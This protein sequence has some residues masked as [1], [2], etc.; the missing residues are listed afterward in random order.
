[1]NLCRLF[2]G[3]VFISACIVSCHPQKGHDTR[4]SDA[5]SLLFKIGEKKDFEQMRLMTDSFEAAGIITPLNA[6]RW[7]G[8]SYYHE[9]NYRISENYYRKALECE[10]NTVEDQLS[11]NKCARRLSELLLVKGDYEGALRVAIPA[12]K[13]MDESGIGSDIDYAIL[14]NNIGCGQLNLGQDKEANESFLSA[15]SYYAQRLLVDSTGRGLQEVVIGYIYTIQAYINTHN[16]AESINW[17]DSADVLLNKFHQT[18]SRKGYFDEYH[19]RIEIMRAVAMQGQ[20]KPAEAAKAYQSFLKTEYSKT[21]PARINANDYLM[22]AHRYSEAA[23]N[24]SYLD[25]AMVH[26]GI[27][28]SLDNV[29]LYML[30]KFRANK[31]AGR[32]DSAKVIAEK[33]LNVLDSAITGQKNDATDELAIIYDTQGKEQKIYQQQTELFRERMWG[34]V[35]SLLLIITFLIIYVL[36]RRR[37]SKILAEKNELLHNANAHIEEL[38]RLK[39][40][41]IQKIIYQ[42]KDTNSSE[43]K[44]DVFISYSRANLEIVKTI[45]K[46]I[47]DATSKHC[48]MDLEGIESGAPRFTESIIEGIEQCEVFLFMRTMQSQNSKY[49]LLEL[50]YAT[51]ESKKHV[52]IVNIDNSDMTKE[53]RFLYGLTN[54]ID[55]GNEPQREKLIRDIVKWT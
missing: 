21:S 28:P 12:M 4:V 7:R 11:Y 20:N 47:E 16:Y 9:G 25:Q 51:E 38:S 2:V 50:N 27:K 15:H 39:T 10:I 52:V 18:D 49:A 1:M 3:L 44:Y 30:P 19:G 45:K 8:V 22:A 26:W 17:I 6:N 43:R 33:I 53:F 31:E 14:L 55:W 29:Q 36:Y 37:Q 35:I 48:W 46:E 40:E 5:D 32:K 24:Y 42:D 41:L 13:K 34:T 23:N 54:T